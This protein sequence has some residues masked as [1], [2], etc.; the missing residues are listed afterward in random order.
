MLGTYFRKPF[1]KSLTAS[2]PHKLRSAPFHP[3]SIRY[4]DLV[5]RYRHKTLQYCLTLNSCLSITGSRIELLI[6]LSLSYGRI[7][8]E[9]HSIDI[10]PIFSVLFR[11]FSSPA[12]NSNRVFGLGLVM[13]KNWSTLDISIDPVAIF[14]FVLLCKV[15]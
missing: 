11:L 10:V 8:H 9:F 14:A 7:L 1:E 15:L 3:P 4:N 12:V 6:S 2:L 5:A 13:Y